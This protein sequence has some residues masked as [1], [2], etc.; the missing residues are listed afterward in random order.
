MF[1]VRHV[2]VSIA[3]PPS[4]V[5]EFTVNGANLPRWASGLGESVQD[6]G[7]EWL[8]EGPLGRIRIRF[9]A[10]NELGVLDHDVVL[11]SGET[12]HNPMRVVPNEAGSE[13]TFSLF[14]LPGVSAQQFA[15]DA[16][17]VERDLKRLKALLE[18]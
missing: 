13:L 18:A 6:A 7:Q 4:A 5:Y 16:D 8:A 1:E 10:L 17:W 12:V 15:T 14:R 3:R 11:P 2:S 9:A